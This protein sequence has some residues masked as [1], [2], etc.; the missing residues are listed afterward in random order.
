M[1]KLRGS[2]NQAHQVNKK[3]NLFATPHTHNLKLKMSVILLFFLLYYLA[4]E[5]GTE[6]PTSTGPV[7]CLYSTFEIVILKTAQT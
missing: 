2:D 6:P 4:G 5:K 1:T 7:S 3:D